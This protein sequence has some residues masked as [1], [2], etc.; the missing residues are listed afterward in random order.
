MVRYSNSL[1]P[2]T[3]NSYKLVLVI[4]MFNKFLVVENNTL[5][6]KVDFLEIINRFLGANIL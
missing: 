4:L 6:K 5:W 3:V 2:N 1:N